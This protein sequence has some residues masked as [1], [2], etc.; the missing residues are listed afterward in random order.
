MKM[1]TF[2]AIEI[3]AYD[4][5]MKIFEFSAKN[6]M[7]EIDCIRQR[8]ELGA[9]TYAFGYVS[10]E[11]TEML[12]SILTEF[13]KIMEGYRVDDYRACAKSALRETSNA[14]LV[15]EQIK[16]KTGLHVDTLGN[17]E[18]R[19]ISYKSIAFQETEFL[20]MIEKPT[21]IM[22]MGEGSLQ[23]S[24][25][26]KECLVTTQ[27]IRLGTMR[28]REKLA[29]MEEKTTDLAGMIDELVSSE[30][31]TFRKLYL[32]EK[33]IKNLIILGNFL[34]KIVKKAGG[35]EQGYLSR[36]VLLDYLEKIKNM[37][38]E[39]MA[40][41]LEIPNDAAEILQQSV[42]IYRSMLREMEVEEIWAPA[43]S[44]CDGLA[45]EYA[46]QHHY[47]KNPHNFENDILAAGRNIA[48]RY[49]CNARHSEAVCN[50]ALI[51]FDG[52]KSVHA[53]GKRERLLLQIACLLHSC[54]KYISMSYSAQSAYNI[55]VSTEI[56]GLSHREREIVAN[57]AK[58]NTMPFPD[59]RELVSTLQRADYLTVAKLTAI[60][61]IA[62]EVDRGH[63][64]K[65][66]TVKTSFKKDVLTVTV[67]SAQNM[68]LEI[69]MMAEKKQFFEDVFG[70]KLNIRQ[71][72]RI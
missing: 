64:Q 4:V 10:Y 41:M 9:D 65:Y 43:Q 13:R 24:L 39:E 58:Y 57:V 33:E 61:R 25:F 55:I 46:E 5:V 29:S 51:I 59:Y 47:L 50:F 6:G 7:R 53:M 68:T 38:P 60:L 19:F 67:D 49:M 62:N 21:A 11:K 28:M 15:L 26:N 17:S 34:T 45:Y 48:K 31:F 36:E 35:R 14:L 42:F 16:S 56:I 40:E 54:G 52:L 27:N 32:K 71:K 8:A 69:G 23:I 72:K 22:D 1:S 30:L 18:H 66:K 20:K 44:F 70:V 2:A 12:C 3:G 37:D 63:R